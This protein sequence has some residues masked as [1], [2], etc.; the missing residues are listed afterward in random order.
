MKLVFVHGWSVTSAK[1]YG[2]LPQV[3]QK[4]APKELNLEIENIYLGEYISF[5]NEVTLEDISRAFESAR[6]EKLG[7]EKFAC[8]THSTGGPVIRLWIDLFFKENIFMIPLSHLIMLA[9]ANHGSSLAIL[10]QGKL[11]RIKAWMDGIE[12]GTKILQWLQLGSFG[13]WDLN[14]S[15]IKYKY[16]QHTF[17]PFVLSGEKIDTHFYDFINN[18]LVEKGTDGV[19]RLSGANINYKSLTLQQNCNLQPIDAIVD[20]HTIKA[21]PMIL[22][23]NIKNTQ[24]SAFEIVPNAS[25]TGDK[26]GI[27]ESVK[28]NKVIKPVVNSI[29]EALQIKTTQEY[30]QII[31]NMKQRSEV[32]QK[33]NQKYIMFVISVKDNYGN[34]IDDYDMLLLAG[35]NYEPSKLPKNFLIDKQKNDIS[36]NLVYY[37]NYN[38]L[39]NIKDSCLSIRIVA[40]PDKGFSHYAPAEFRSEWVDLEKVLVANETLMIEVILERLISKNTFVLNKANDGVVDFAKREVGNEFI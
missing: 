14:H 33:N 8:I 18:Y 24:K 4:V 10:G 30:K 16:N 1:T 5:H 20:G 17:F 12:V 9:P 22:K 11:S 39:K 15:W 19:I 6:K 40:R 34:K 36:G 13:Q 7:D 38:K 3:L 21:Y 35:K 28:K 25:H 23:G 32:S 37:L 26:Y 27:M 29:L 31:E 2:D